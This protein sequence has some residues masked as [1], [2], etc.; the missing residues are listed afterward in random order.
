[1]YVGCAVNCQF[2]HVH[3]QHELARPRHV[4][5]SA[6]AVCDE[7]C[8]T[9][10]ADADVPALAPAAASLQEFAI[11]K[12]DN[13]S[14][15]RPTGDGGNGLVMTHGVVVIV[16]VMVLMTLWVVSGWVGVDCATE[17]WI[18]YRTVRL[19]F[20][21]YTCPRQISRTGKVCST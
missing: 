7:R 5:I 10:A 16:V 3:F 8:S 9:A 13:P 18:A 2:E 11:R 15:L 6:A 17:F 19:V 14:R 12:H 21:Y 20:I 4:A 1:V